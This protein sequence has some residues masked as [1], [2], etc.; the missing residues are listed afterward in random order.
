MHEILQTTGR[1]GNKTI[2][3]HNMGMKR[4]YQKKKKHEWMSWKKI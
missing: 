1:Q 4:T 2:L 3:G